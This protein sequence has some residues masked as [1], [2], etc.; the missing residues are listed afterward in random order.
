MEA[1]PPY[2][3][4]HQALLSSYYEPDA[5]LGQN[6]HKSLSGWPDLVLKD[7]SGSALGAGPRWRVS[8]GR[9]H[10]RCRPQQSLSRFWVPR[11]E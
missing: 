10:L 2:L 3:V 4:T 7:N 5:A 1:G 8:K 9:G 11:N 6:R